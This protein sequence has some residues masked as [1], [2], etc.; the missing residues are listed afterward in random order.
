MDN[1]L[2]KTLDNSI[3]IIGK[4][5]LLNKR[6]RLHLKREFNA[7]FKED[8]ILIDLPKDDNDLFSLLDFFESN[9]LNISLDDNTAK[10]VKTAYSKAEQFKEFSDQAK[11]IWNGEFNVDEFEHFCSVLDEEL[12]RTLYPLQLL[13]AYH[14]AFSQNACNFSVPGAGK[15]SIVYGAYSYLKA[16]TNDKQV[17]K[18]LIVGPLSSFGPWEN[19]YKE[20]FG[21]EIEIKRISG[22]LPREE[23]EGYFFRSNTAEITLISY[24]GLIGL[25]NEIK[26][27]LLNNNVLF[28][29]DEAHKIKNTSGGSIATAAL[30][31]AVYANSR[32]I[33]TGTP[34]PNGYRDLYNLFE[35]I[36]PKKGIIKYS[37]IQLD[38]M[39][40]ASNDDRVED[41]LDDLSPYFIRIKKSD[42]NL[43]PKTENPPIYVEMDSAQSKIYEIIEKKI[44]TSFDQD[45][46]V[47]DTFKQAKMIRLIQAASNPSLLLSPIA[48]L[49]SESDILSEIDEEFASLIQK[50]HTQRIV[51]NSFILAREIIEE[52]ISKG[53]RVIVWAVYVESILMFSR[54]LEECD[55]KHRVL[56]GKTP[57][58]TEV[59]EKDV[60]TREKIIDEFNSK[61]SSFDVIVANPFAVA[62]SISLHK[63]CHNAIYLERNFDGA[64]FLQS[65]D[66]IHR[67]GLPKDINTNYYYIIT[68][69]T[70]S[71]VIHNR[72]LE[73]EQIL[74]RITE[75]REIPLFNFMADE[76]NEN[77]VKAVI[78]FYEKRKNRG[79]S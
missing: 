61:S 54:Y 75:S 71:E 74:L 19:E 14:L 20:C 30:D 55:I 24:Q 79:N 6:K 77:D 1:F 72:L 70:I 78:K 25:T 4:V 41:L 39:T 58:E 2:L 65:K 44:V 40:T 57:I 63:R 15:T 52:K 9:N 66:R 12:D 36:W 8:R 17:N 67:Y 16:Q 69:D 32:V 38:D 56:Y 22:E 11:R 5:S 10:K 59:T 43:P 21:K 73:K 26:Y 60:I 45:N 3:V 62:E 49:T 37:P 64:R 23:K 34:A 27:F 13:A 33:L 76:L 18:M 31:L 48:E 50:Y 51:P 47:V 28:V 29:L 35:F 53:E 42:L 7:S 68:K 46:Y